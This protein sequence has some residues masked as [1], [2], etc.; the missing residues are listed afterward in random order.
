MQDGAGAA[1]P[2]DLEVQERLCRRP[3]RR[4]ADVAALVIDLEERGRIQHSLMR[5]A[6]RDRQPQR[7]A[8]DHRAEVPA[9]AHDPAARVEAAADLGQLARCGVERR[10][11]GGNGT[12]VYD[13]YDRYAGYVRYV[14][15]RQ[16]PSYPSYLSYPS[17]P[18]CQATVCV[19]SMR[20]GVQRAGRQPPREAR[21]EC[22]RAAPAACTVS[23]AMLWRSGPGRHA[24]CFAV[25][26]RSEPRRFV[27]CQDRRSQATS[28]ASRKNKTSGVVSHA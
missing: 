1:L 14:R 10:G 11:H 5:A 4:R 24:A 9:R 21:R 17:Y 19:R 27:P 7:L 12:T 6:R 23:S 28:I 22:A 8:R 3:A 2:D 13:G 20:E 16:A 26:P 18:S 15:Y 25:T